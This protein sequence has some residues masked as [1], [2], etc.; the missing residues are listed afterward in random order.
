MRR[1]HAPKRTPRGEKATAPLWRPLGAASKWRPE[2]LF[3]RINFANEKKIRDE[4]L[5]S[6]YHCDFK[7]SRLQSCDFLM[8]TCQQIFSPSCRNL[9]RV[10]ICQRVVSAASLPPAAFT[11][12]SRWAAMPRGQ[13]LD[14]KYMSAFTT[15]PFPPKS[16]W[17]P[18]HQL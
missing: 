3:Y 14:L 13:T 9:C 4:N 10:L 12:P 5:M 2:K 17:T 15:P 1:G 11:Q 8:R 7:K 18:N 6:T 16:V